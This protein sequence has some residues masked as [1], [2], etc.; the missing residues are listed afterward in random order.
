MPA[1]IRIRNGDLSLI[2][3][4]SFA[5]FAFV[6]KHSV[7][8]A[9]GTSSGLWT[10]GNT[11]SAVLSL[12]GLVQPIA[13]AR[14]AAG[15]ALAASGLVGS[16]WVFHFAGGMAGGT[17]VPGDQL[18]V[19][20][21]DRPRE[22]TGAGFGLR[23]RDAEGRP[24]FDSRQ[25]YMKVLDAREFSVGLGYTASIPGNHACLVLQNAFAK[26]MAP[27]IPEFGQWLIR[28]GFLRSISGGYAASLLN[29]AEGS[30]NPNLPPPF[31]PVSQLQMRVMTVDVSE[32]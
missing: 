4:E 5:N 2:I 16:N 12:P 32:Y 1:G 15:W 27:T 9:N 23:V 19:F 3:D 31:S 7:T 28:V 8:F 26:S 6:S 18:E 11:A 24:V 10:G 29:Y 14:G 22:I 13:F 20:V 30:Y 21:F 17:A 25:K